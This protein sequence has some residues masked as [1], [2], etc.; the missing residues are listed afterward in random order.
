M[1]ETMTPTAAEA[2]VVDEAAALVAVTVRA[3]L[4]AALRAARCCGCRH[5][6]VRAVQTFQWADALLPS[7]ASAVRRGDGHGEPAA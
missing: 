6:R 2:T 3:T 4:V 7:A 5:C 1:R